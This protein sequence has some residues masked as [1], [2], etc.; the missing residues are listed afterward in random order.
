MKNANIL[1]LGIGNL[2][3]HDEGVGV[4][5]A[6]K[7]KE[8][9]LPPGI[10][11]MDGGTMGLN[12]L[13][14]IEN[15]DRVIVVDTVIVGDPPGT[16]YRFT[17]ESLVQNKPMLRTA[18]GVDFTDVIKTAEMLGTKPKE[19]IFV[20]IEPADMSEGIGLSEV[21]EKRVPTLI[22]MVMRELEL[23]GFSNP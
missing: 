17:D 1:I 4:H 11:V 21:I 3:L 20:G 16:I 13:Y 22:K 23:E 6:H 9:A 14:Y 15:R 8:M 5:V 12:L 2:L 19:I 18:H 7:M 10:E